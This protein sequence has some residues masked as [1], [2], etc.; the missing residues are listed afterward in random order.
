M[1]N[2]GPKPTLIIDGEE[3]VGAKQ[4][5]VVNL[6]ILVA[7]ESELII[8]VSCVEAGRWRAKSEPVRDRAADPVCERPRQAD[9]AG[10]PID[11]RFGRARVRPVSR[12]GGHRRQV[13]ANALELPD[14]RDGADL[15]RP[16][17]VDRRVC[18][19][20]CPGRRAG[21]R[22]FRDRRPHRRLRSVRRRRHV[23]EAVAEAG[24]Q[25]RRG[26]DRH[27]ERRWSHR[28]R[29]RLTHERLSRISFP[30]SSRRSPP[31]PSRVPRQSAS[32]RMFACP[33]AASSGPRSWWRARLCT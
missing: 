15:H 24:A 20:P 31:P 28:R 18:Q 7:A 11:G 1:V 25:L 26:R 22:G 23:P 3:L 27:G 9:G 4:N 29:R 10:L 16:C 8:P 33:A 14:L 19:R 5:R 2:R 6:T 32:A 13:G 12:L 17:D 30:A 21:R